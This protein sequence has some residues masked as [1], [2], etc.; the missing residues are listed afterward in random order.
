M[1]I[2]SLSHFDFR[3]ALDIFENLGVKS[4]KIPQVKCFFF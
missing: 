4:E 1:G 3:D 2:K